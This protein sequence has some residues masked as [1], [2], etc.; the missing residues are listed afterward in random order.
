MGG[1]RHVSDW[2]QRE[3]GEP[4][5][6]RAATFAG[7]FYPGWA[8]ACRR[9]L[10][11]M[12]SKVAG[13][14][15]N[16][17]EGRSRGKVYDEGGWRGGPAIGGVV[18]HA[19]WVYSGVTAARTISRVAAWCPEVVVVFGAVHVRDRNKASVYRAGRWDGVVGEVE[20]DAGY[21]DELLRTREVTDDA[22]V[23]EGEHSIEV[24]VPLIAYA[25]PGVRIVPVMV[26]PGAWAAGVGRAAGEAAKQLGRRAAFVA[27]TDLTHYGPMFGFTPAG[28]GEEGVRWAKEVNDRRFIERVRQMDAEG[29]VPEAAEHRN[30][31]GAGAVAAMLGAMG[32][33]GVE[34]FEELE[35]TSSAEVAAGRGDENA[36]GYVAG[37]VGRGVR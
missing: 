7:R 14:K 9:M 19:G 17:D 11:S 21:C 3:A 6:A 23:H 25:M 24:E 1:E 16:N 18:P 32:V 12:F 8:E 29:V 10:D 33:Y 22:G 27:S 34:I 37:V 35:H 26:S 13:E 31:C 36:V 28:R 4:M 2:G 5:K 15:E 20:V 30:A